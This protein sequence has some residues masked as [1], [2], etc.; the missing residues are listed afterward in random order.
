MDIPS[1]DTSS[2]ILFAGIRFTIA[3]IMVI[4]S[5]SIMQRKF[6]RPKNAASWGR[7][8]FLMLFQTVLQY[9]FFYIALAHISGVKSSIIEALNMF[10]VILFSAFVFHY[11]KMTLRKTAGCIIGFLGVVMIQLP[12]QSIDLSMSMQGE[13]FLILSTISAALATNFGKMFTKKEDPVMLSGYQ[14]LM[15]GV[16]MAIYG[17]ALGG[18]LKMSGPAAA[19]LL[20]MAFISAAA[21]T[22]WSIL[23]KYNRVSKVA[24]F[25][26][27]NPMIGVILSALLLGEHEQALSFAAL[28]ALVLV[29]IGIVVV[30]REPAT[31]KN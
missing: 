27:M 30:F 19:L 8:S 7:V 2:Q 11:E 31:K 3:G 16:V 10:L 12:G 18:H 25:G 6:L 28:L 4:L 24:V 17:A 15:G 22:F 21:Y 20:Y 14:F 13:G 1:S 9:Y 23:M 26:F 29:T 5:G